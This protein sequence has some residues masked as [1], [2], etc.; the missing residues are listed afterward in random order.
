[1]F[2]KILGSSCYQFSQFGHTT[3]EHKFSL[4]AE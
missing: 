4:S 3:K 2:W 1:L